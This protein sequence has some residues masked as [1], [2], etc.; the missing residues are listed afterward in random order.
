[1]ASERIIR[2]NEILKR[3]IADLIEKKQFNESNCLVSVTSVDTTPDLR[4]ARVN[5]SVFGGNEES[6][7]NALRF[8]NRNRNDLQRNISRHVVM[9]YTPVLEF[10]IDGNLEAGDRVLD[11]IREL[12]QDES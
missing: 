7:K 8:L 1:M 2:V 4:H 6:R 11:I 12:E 5:I 9:K 10:V 3:E